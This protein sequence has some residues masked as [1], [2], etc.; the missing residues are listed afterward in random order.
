VLLELLGEGGMGGVFLAE[1]LVTGERVAL[2]VIAP[3]LARHPSFAQRF[4]GEA[5]AIMSIDHPNVIHIES[6]GRLPDGTLYHV[7]ELLEGEDLAAV[8]QRSGR[9]TSSEALPYV[10]QICMGL[11]AA[12][13]RQIIH[14][15]LKPEN[16]FVLAGEE[17]RLKLLDFG[18]AKLLDFSEMADLTATGVVMGSPMFIAPE[19]AKGDKRGIGPHTDIYSLGVIIYMML[20]GAPPFESDDICAL[21]FNHISLPPR[22]LTFLE[23]SV[24]VRVA[25]LV[26]CCLQKDPAHRPASAIEVAEEMAAAV[27]EAAAVEESVTRVVNVAVITGPGIEGPGLKDHDPTQIHTP[28]PDPLS[29]PT[30]PTAPTLTDAVSVIAPPLELTWGHTRDPEPQLVPRVEPLPIALVQ[31]RRPHS[32]AHG[33]ALLAGLFGVTAIVL[34]VLIA[35]RLMYSG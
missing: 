4:E 35:V 20:G 3:H 31:P 12:H 34:L 8:M 29:A 1:H 21:L 27:A 24:P 14:R 2:K 33:L 30:G 17:P 19:Q 28:L 11:H 5:R 6:Y 23:P 18:I 16:I 15:D 7:L 22:P 32:L 13:E 10:Q 25:R 9:F 26:H